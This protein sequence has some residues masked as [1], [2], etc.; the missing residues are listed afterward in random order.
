M[1]S[2]PQ[3]HG[4]RGDNLMAVEFEIC[5]DP[6]DLEAAYALA[7][8]AAH[9]RGTELPHLGIYEARFAAGELTVGKLDGV[10][11]SMA[12]WHLDD[13]TIRHTY[14]VVAPAY[15]RQKICRMM[16]EWDSAHWKSL[17]ATEHESKICATVSRV[18]AA[19]VWRDAEL[20]AVGASYV[21]TETMGTQEFWVYR[22]VL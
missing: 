13:K 21:K 5:K 11:V 12:L 22:R 3:D 6:K 7:V 18:E 14:A 19:S 4:D 1:H 20:T 9:E 8:D 10:V 17:G 2:E 16:R 15:R